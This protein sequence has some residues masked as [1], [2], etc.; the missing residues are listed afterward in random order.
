MPPFTSAPLQGSPA[1]PAAGPLRMDLPPGVD[2][3]RVLADLSDDG[4]AAPANLVDG[5]RQV[6]EE[7]AAKGVDLKIVVLGADPPWLPNLRDLAN[8]VGAADGG[9]VLVLSPHF[10]GTYSDTLS[11]IQLQ[12]GEIAASGKPMVERAEQFLAEATSTGFPWT[13][14]TLALVALVI[15]GIVVQRRL[16]RER[17]RSAPR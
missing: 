15:V 14:V 5:M 17:T 7:A 9:T 6:V 12:S 10:F 4:V 2:L 13:A 1:H 11:R 8:D 16:G 3:E